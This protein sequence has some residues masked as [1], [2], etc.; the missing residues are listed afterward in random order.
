MNKEK[1]RKKKRSEN[2]EKKSFG[3]ISYA[4]KMKVGSI[5]ILSL[6]MKT[7]YATSN[8][9]N[10]SNRSMIEWLLYGKHDLTNKK[11]DST[12]CDV[13]GVQPSLVTVTI[14]IR[15]GRKYLTSNIV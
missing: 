13:I 6:L 3:S 8:L 4:M 5:Y 9:Y 2:G 10:I 1:T 14:E 7:S 12:I 11:H 15:E